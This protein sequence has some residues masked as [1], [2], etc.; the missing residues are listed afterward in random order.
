MSAAKGSRRE[1]QLVLA[2]HDL[3]WA[4]VRIPTSGS[5]TDRDLPDVLALRDH[6]REPFDSMALA[7][8]VKANKDQYASLDTDE[9]HALEAF[10]SRAG[11]AC[12]PVVA[13]HPNHDRWHCWSSY[14]IN[15]RD[16]GYSITQAMYPGKGLTDLESFVTAMD[17]E[18]ESN[19]GRGDE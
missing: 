14:E 4:A 6:P 10:A 19:G 11:P 9:V 8:E 16:A 1:R 18:S 5:A 7:I 13:T 12:L 17:T 15:E 2:L 3:G